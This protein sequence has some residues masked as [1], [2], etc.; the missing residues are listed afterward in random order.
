[1]GTLIDPVKVRL[2]RV[3]GKSVAYHDGQSS[4]APLVPALAATTDGA[5]KLLQRIADRI[6][7]LAG[8]AG[9]HP[10]LRERLRRIVAPALHVLERGT[11]LQWSAALVVSAGQSDSI[12]DRKKFNVI[13]A[14]HCPQTVSDWLAAAR[15][16]HE[17]QAEVIASAEAHVAH[18]RLM[19]G[20]Q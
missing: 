20:A 10:R 3:T 14:P 9:K 4:V 15:R 2:G 18:L 17:D 8:L 5:E 12:E 1:M 13:A 16:A 11:P 19:G 6:R 7:A